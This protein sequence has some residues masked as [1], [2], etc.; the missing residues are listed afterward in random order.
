MWKIRKSIVIDM[1][2]LFKTYA[3]ILILGFSVASF[4]TASAQS[5][6]DTALTPE[7]IKIVSHILSM[8]K[9][10]QNIDMM[11]KQISMTNRDILS[12]MYIAETGTEISQKTL[13]LYDEKFQNYM[14]NEYFPY[15]KNEMAPQ[16][17]AQYVSLEE[18]RVIDDF[19]KTDAG[20]KVALHSNVITQQIIQKTEAHV[21]TATQEI[22]G[23]VMQNAQQTD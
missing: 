21:R 22:L 3:A 8:S 11:L 1:R 18:M 13:Q 14:T 15:M 20:K 16:I 10:D 5:S 19:Y 2:T 4:N 12:R 23:S 7:Y 17:Y 6:G 9:F